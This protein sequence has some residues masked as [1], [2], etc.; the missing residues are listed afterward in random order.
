MNEEQSNT[1][2]KSD[3]NDISGTKD[4]N[5]TNEANSANAG[6]QINESLLARRL[7][8]T[9]NATRAEK[10]DCENGGVAVKEPLFKRFENFWYHYKWATIAVILVAAIITILAVQCATK[11]EPD[12]Y[13]L[14]AGRS[15]SRT[16]ETGKTKSDYDTILDSLADIIGDADG[17]GNRYI[18]L[19]TKSYLSAT[20][21]AEVEA[22][23]SEAVANGKTPP[24]EINESLLQQ[25]L[26][27]LKELFKTGDY[28]IFL[29]DPEIYDV[30]QWYLD[31]EISLFRDLG[32]YLPQ[33]SSAEFY[34]DANGNE[35]K[36]AILLRSLTICDK[37]GLRDLP[38]DTLLCF[39]TKT[40]FADSGDYSRAE[41]NL[42]DMLA[43]KK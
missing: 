28:Y 37:D 12:A 35:C 3:I 10:S 27:D 41:D 24:Y 17:D 4:T 33:G 6:E 36:N 1:S 39:R 13:I 7:G 11:A 14:Y 9:D 23:N 16:V 5:S 2:K 34:R 22:A 40:Y 26:A 20:Q 43:Y 25:D 30:Y 19:D 18:A 31:E 32:E 8:L 21:R 38:E 15:I 42:R 29:I